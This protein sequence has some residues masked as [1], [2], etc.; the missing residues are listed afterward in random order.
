[1]RLEQEEHIIDIVEACSSRLEGVLEIGSVRPIGRPSFKGGVADATQAF[2]VDGASRRDDCV[3]I[4]SNPQF[5]EMVDQAVTKAKDA[6]VRL[7]PQLGEVVC[8]PLVN[9]RWEGRSYA[10]YSRLE[11]FSSNRY[12]RRL[13]VVSSERGIFDWLVN[14]FHHTREECA[15][16]E[17]RH[18]NFLKPLQT[19]S[20]DEDLSSLVRASTA[21][22]EGEVSHGRA[23]AFKCLQHGDFWHGNVLFS[24]GPIAALS[25]IQKNFH[26]IDWAGSRLSG[27]PGIDALRFAISAFGQ[28]SFASK[29]VRN[30]V[31]LV[32]LSDVEFSLSCFC[33]LGWLAS[34]LNEFP[35]DRF[36]KMASGIADF[37][38]EH[39]FIK[40]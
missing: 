40:R 39:D 25:P 34:N 2:F 9:G 12:L 1:M 15:E 13:Q 24:R 29:K 7:G 6:R 26:V 10:V 35:K 38:V 17:D 8:T 23:R 32:D 36:N 28:G 3:L 37:L 30:F 33:A 11:G 16:R 27:Y 19:L 31:R 18:Q 14:V 20:G 4:L 5:P 21:T 22:L